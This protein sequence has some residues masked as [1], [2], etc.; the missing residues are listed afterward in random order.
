VKFDDTDLENLNRIDMGSFIISAEDMPFRANKPAGEIAKLFFGKKAPQLKEYAFRTGLEAAKMGI[1]VVGALFI[2][3]PFLE[4]FWIFSSDFLVFFFRNAVQPFFDAPK[5]PVLS[6][7]FS[8]LS[9]SAIDLFDFNMPKT[10]HELP[11]HWL[12]MAESLVML[13]TFCLIAFGFFLQ[14]QPKYEIFLP[15]WMKGFQSLATVNGLKNAII[16]LVV[17]LLAISFLNKFMGQGFMTKLQGVDTLV[18]DGQ[19]LLLS[20][21]AIGILIASIA[22]FVRLVLSDKE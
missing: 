4:I 7:F 17:I 19:N 21:T 13:F 11:K 8:L 10:L 15:P 1:Y 3:I 14:L 12:N 9:D 5:S 6:Q 18:V 2:L 20:A 22:V 16:S